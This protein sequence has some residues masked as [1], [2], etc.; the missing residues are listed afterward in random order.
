M[1]TEKITD[2]IVKVISIV[3]YISLT[4][5]IAFFMILA[6]IAVSLTIIEGDIINLIGAG[7]C[8]FITWV[9]WSVRGAML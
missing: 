4:V 7:G 1:R 8:G 2:A 3:G 6:I 5:F 9:L